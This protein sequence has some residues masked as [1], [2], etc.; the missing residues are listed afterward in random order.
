MIKPLLLGLAAGALGV[1]GYAVA[2]R[3]MRRP[4]EELRV[5]PWKEGKLAYARAVAQAA[6][7]QGH[8]V[9]AWDPKGGME[10]E[11]AWLQSKP[12]RHPPITDFW[13]E[14]QDSGYTDPN[15]AACQARDAGFTSHAEHIH[16]RMGKSTAP[17]FEAES[18]R[19]VDEFEKF[20]EML[21]R[22][23]EDNERHGYATGLGAS[24]LAT[25]QRNYAGT[26]RRI[27]RGG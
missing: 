8:E 21:T 5:G 6:R 26:I 23:A 1:A 2:T 10:F 17:L 24:Q 11:P 9:W 14:E 22:L 16:S 27:L 18:G 20:A 12:M 19:F 15:C 7:E 13:A 25:E 3:P 4:H